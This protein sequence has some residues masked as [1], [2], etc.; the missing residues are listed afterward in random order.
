MNHILY[1]MALIILCCGIILITI[2]ITKAST[3]S[4]KTTNQVL[5]EKQEYLKNNS[6]QI[7]NETIYDLRPSNIYSKMFSN[8]SVWFGYNEFNEKDV[9]D[10]IYV[11]L[12]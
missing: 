4:F 6:L 7:G 2:Y 10:K 1:N 8:P 3:N 9:T 11:K 5:L 12:S